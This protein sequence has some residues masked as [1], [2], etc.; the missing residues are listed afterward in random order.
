VSRA[1]LR[2]ESSHFPSLLPSHRTGVHKKMS[3]I[4]D[5]SAKYIRFRL[6]IQSLIQ[7]FILKNATLISLNPSMTAGTLQ[8]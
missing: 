3:Y 6:Q 4:R 1:G 5:I 7:S 2:R 8:V